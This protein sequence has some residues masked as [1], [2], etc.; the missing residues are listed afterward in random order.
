MRFYEVLW[1]FVWLCES[2]WVFARFYELIFQTKK[3]ALT[4]DPLLSSWTFMS[5]MKT[6]AICRPAE[7]K[8]ARTTEWPVQGTPMEITDPCILR[9]S[10]SGRAPW[11][12]PQITCANGTLGKYAQW[13]QGFCSTRGRRRGSWWWF[14]TFQEPRDAW[15][16]APAN[17][18]VMKS[19][20][21]I[22]RRD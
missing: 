15:F 3:T 14:R 12:Q 22:E 2:L 18:N 9:A 13:I 21:C 7:H 17:R 6:H 8:S 16:S 1:I 19:L 11:L 5:Q 4:N 20:C 10:D